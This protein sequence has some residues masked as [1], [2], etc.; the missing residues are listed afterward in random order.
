MTVDDL[1]L[2]IE[3]LAREVAGRQEAG[4]LAVQ[5]AQQF[6]SM[7]TRLQ[8]ALNALERTEVRERGVNRQMVERF[9]VLEHRIRCIQGDLCREPRNGGAFRRTG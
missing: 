1:A 4:P 6:T 7:L 8:L 5:D 9:A 3:Q 2:A